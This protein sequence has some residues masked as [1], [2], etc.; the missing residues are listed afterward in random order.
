MTPCLTPAWRRY[1]MVRITRA[2]RLLEK[3]GAGYEACPQGAHR[4]ECGSKKT[5]QENPAPQGALLNLFAPGGARDLMSRERAKIWNCWIFKDLRGRR[6][7]ALGAGRHPC[8]SGTTGV[9]G[10]PAN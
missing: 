3:K 7:K 10:R 8:L 4:K 9:S 5:G 1:G 6:G 2:V